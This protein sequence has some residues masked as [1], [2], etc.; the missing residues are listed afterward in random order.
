MTRYASTTDVSAA[1]SR[2]EIERTLARYGASSFGYMTTQEP[3][4]A[5][6]IMFRYQ[7]R[8]YRITI[9]LPARTDPALRKRL[10]QYAVAPTPNAGAYDQ[11]IKQRWR[12]VAL[13]IKATLE[14]V[15]SGIVTFEEAF[16][17]AAML[18]TGETVGAWA[19]SDLDDAARRGELPAHLPGLGGHLLPSGTS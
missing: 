6:L 13:Y 1:K 15:E 11:A 5:A 8:N 9:P 16:L 17:A 3:V 12:A 18:P 4:P 2:E 7:A 14:A 10:N 19:N